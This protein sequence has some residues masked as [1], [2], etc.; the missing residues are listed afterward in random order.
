MMSLI[1]ATAAY[2]QKLSK[3]GTIYSFLQVQVD[4]L[5]LLGDNKPKGPVYCTSHNLQW[6]SI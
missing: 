5:V 2:Q 4:L 1:R 3:C 6:P